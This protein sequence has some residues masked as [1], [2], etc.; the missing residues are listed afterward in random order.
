M[1]SQLQVPRSVWLRVNLMWVGV[2]LLS[3]VANLYVAFNY[4]TETWVDFKVF[5][6]IG[7]TLVFVLLQAFYLALHAQRNAEDTASDKPS[8]SE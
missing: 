4:S 5:G 2:F 6:L 3:G 1:G 7:A 8:P